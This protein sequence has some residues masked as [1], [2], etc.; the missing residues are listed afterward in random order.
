MFAA[1]STEFA[2]WH[3]AN[4]NDKRRARLNV[5][6][7]LLDQIPYDSPPRKRVV[8]PAR[9]KALGYREPDHSRL[10]IPAKY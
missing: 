6:S 3:I 9:D 7:H 8:L 1:T 5:I 2:R 10:Y 4:A